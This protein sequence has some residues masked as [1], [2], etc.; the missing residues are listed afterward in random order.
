ML[1]TAV[2]FQDNFVLE[3]PSNASQIPKACPFSAIHLLTT[4]TIASRVQPFFWKPEIG[5]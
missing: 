4:Q 2:L 5:C 1:S 3:L